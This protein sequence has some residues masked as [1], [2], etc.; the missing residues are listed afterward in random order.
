MR[1]RQSISVYADSLL[2]VGLIPDASRV[3]ILPS[4]E[5]MRP[6]ISFILSSRK[7]LYRKRKYRSSGLLVLEQNAHVVRGHLCL[8]TFLV[9]NTFGA[10]WGFSLTSLCAS[11]SRAHVEYPAMAR[12]KDKVKHN[13]KN[14]AS[15]RL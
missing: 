10:P 15:I 12:R 2:L 3:L 13:E 5:E 9:N 4:L 6:R 11:S 1:R 7:S 14:M 8:Y